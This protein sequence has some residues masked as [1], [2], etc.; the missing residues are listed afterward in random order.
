[1]TVKYL[2]RTYTVSLEDKRRIQSIKA[3]LFFIRQ[4][5]RIKVLFKPMDFV[6]YGGITVC[7]L[8]FALCTHC[9]GV[10]GGFYGTAA[11]S[12]VNA[13]WDIRNQWFSSVILAMA[14]NA[15]NRGREHKKKIAALH[16]IYCNSMFD[17]EELL[18]RYCG[19]TP[20]NPIHPLYSQKCFDDTVAFIKHAWLNHSIEVDAQYL[21]IIKQVL[22]RLDKLEERFEAGEIVF[23]DHF[24]Y[25]TGSVIDELNALSTLNKIS[26]QEIIKISKHLLYVVDEL[27][28]PWRKDLKSKREILTILDKY[29]Q[30]RISKSHYY[31]ML[32]NGIEYDYEIGG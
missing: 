11:R 2:G 31:G 30:N 3:K 4:C 15:L 7:W 32:L 5:R 1:M 14:I 18:A 22:K 29:P 16:K 10:R 19:K 28:I 24:D 25:Y 26:I 9:I 12:A 20:F 27:R 17:F 21:V 13:I 6:L 23:S 8:I